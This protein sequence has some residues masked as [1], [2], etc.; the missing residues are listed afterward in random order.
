MVKENY[1]PLEDSAEPVQPEKTPQERRKEKWDN[2]WFY[3]KKP[4]WIAIA[5]ILVVLYVWSPWTPRVKP[6]YT[7]GIISSKYWSDDLQQALSD[8]LEPYGE[9]LNGDGQ[10][11]VDTVLYL[12]P[13]D[14]KTIGA[15]EYEAYVVKLMGDIEACTSAV[16][17]CDEFNAKIYGTESGMFARLSDYAHASEDDE[18]P[19]SDFGL[20]WQSVN[21]IGQNAR[22]RNSK[23]NMYFCLRANVGTMEKHPEVF[24]Q[25]KALLERFR[26]NAP[27]DSARLAQVLAD[28]EKQVS[29]TTAAKSSSSGKNSK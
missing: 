28:A 17:L 21:G 12:L 13:E 18:W 7:V 3:Y 14:S 24:E 22:F 8:A 16:Y 1:M 25:G 26:T 23:T 27:K 15:E 19:V 5:V 4:F 29:S 20:D 11:V 6:D 2:F 9:D 10:V